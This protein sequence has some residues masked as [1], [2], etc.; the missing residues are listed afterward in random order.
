LKKALKFG[1]LSIFLMVLG[2]L[3]APRTAQATPLYTFIGD[4]STAN[5]FGSTYT[6]IIGDAGDSTN[7]TY[8]ARLIIDTTG[9]DNTVPAPAY[10]DA[11]DFKVVNSLINNNTFSLVDAPGGATNWESF[12]NNGQATNDCDSSGGG[13]KVC[14]KDPDSNTLAPV[15]DILKWD[16]TFSSAD[17]ISFGHIG[18]SYNNYDGSINGQ[19]TSIKYASLPGPTTGLLLG[20]GLIVLGGV[21]RKFGPK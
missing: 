14:S 19:N 5:C 9:Y 10:I 7:T 13:F 21:A 4:C 2:L 16:W 8:T 3:Y 17:Q 20:T 18:A 12:F 15:G 11:V 1:M 6:L